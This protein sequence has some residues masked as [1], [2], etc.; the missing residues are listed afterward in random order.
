MKIVVFCGGF[1]TRMWPASTKSNPKQFAPILNGKSFYR[2]TLDRFER[3]FDPKDIYISTEIRYKAIAMEQAK[4]LPEQNFIFEPERRD[5]MAAVGLVLAKL[6]TTDDDTVFFSWS[7]H[8]IDQEEV[9]LDAVELS[10]S[11]TKQTGLPVSINQPPLYPTTQNG[12]VK[13]G[14]KKEKK[15]EFDVFE[16]DDFV[17]KPTSSIA[18]KLF[19]SKEY[20]V[21]TGYGSW[22]INF[23]WDEYQKNA[24]DAFKLLQKISQVIEGGEFLEIGNLYGQ[25]E[26]QSVDYAVFEKI[27]KGQRLTISAKFGWKDA[28]T[29]QLLFDALSRDNQTVNLSNV[30]LVEISSSGNLVSTSNSRVV[31]LVGVSGIAVIEINGAIL[32]LDLSKSSEVKDLYMSLESL[33]PESVS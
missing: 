7:D 32:V 13:L 30:N 28:G 9:F 31:S 12:W 29:W 4:E 26:K 5:T 2:L 11:L 27:P 22:P 10:L 25:I 21:H 23:L 24:P 15:G 20:L 1:G 18:Q 17:E 16:I 33:Y 8:I 3:R 14:A 6:K 19:K